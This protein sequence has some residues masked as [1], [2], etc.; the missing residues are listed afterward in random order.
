MYTTSQ[1]KIFRDIVRK[2]KIKSIGCTFDR[3]FPKDFDF[4]GESHSFAELVFVR[5]GK[6]Q[7][8]ENEKVYLLH[9]G[10]MI[11]HAPMEFHRI[12][13]DD[14]TSPHV[15]NL[16]IKVNGELPKELY[17]G[18]FHL[19]D[20]QNERFLYCFSRAR[21][22][23]TKTENTDSGQLAADA[24]E[25]FLLELCNQPTESNVLVTDSS[26]LIYKKLVRD[27]QA[28]VC[29][30]ISLEELAQQNFISVSYVKKLFR[31]YANE[32]PKKFYDSLRINEAIALLNRGMSITEISEQMNFSSPNFFAMF[33]KKNTGRT[34]TEY[35]RK[36]V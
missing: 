12:K 18:V 26:A 19:N 21:D 34:P 23:V 20:E 17:K 5:S 3:V 25:A 36:K 32:T 31:M 7:I 13:S 24:V 30:S 29:R 15:L 16:S 4:Q 35:K 6:V 8:I 28:A 33:F 14:E 10:E 1:E 11:I 2:F 9:G 22:F 27:M